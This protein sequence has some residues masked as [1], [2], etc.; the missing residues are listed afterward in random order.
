MKEPSVT[1]LQLQTII[2]A[3]DA[4][5]AERREGA[6]DRIGQTPAGEELHRSLLCSSS[7][8]RGGNLLKV[9][10]LRTSRSMKAFQL[11]NTRRPQL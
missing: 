9:L 7:E 8:S 5:S 1:R 2:P 3:E 11:L 6:D 4:D 10:R